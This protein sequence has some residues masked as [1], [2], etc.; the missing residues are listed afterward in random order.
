MICKGFDLMYEVVK[1]FYETTTPLKFILE[2][3]GNQADPFEKTLYSILDHLDNHIYPDENTHKNIDDAVKSGHPD[4]DFFLLFISYLLTLY[5]RDLMSAN[6]RDFILA[7][8]NSVYNIS[9]SLDISSF[10]TESQAYYYQSSGYYFYIKNNFSKGD[11]LNLLANQKMPK[12]SPRFFDFIIRA[13]QIFGNL[14]RLDFLP[15]FDKELLDENN[16]DNFYI[17]RAHFMNSIFTGN[18]ELAEKYL[19]ILDKKYSKPMQWQNRSGKSKCA[20]EV[21]KGNYEE[22]DIDYPEMYICLNYYKALKNKEVEVAKKQYSNIRESYLYYPCYYLYY[23]APYHQSFVTGWFEN[24]ETIINNKDEH[25][26]HYMMDF[27][28][29]RYFLYKNN[30]ELARFYYAQLIKNCVKHDAIGRLKFEMQFAVELS[31]NSFF[32]FTFPRQIYNSIDLRKSLEKAMSPHTSNLY[33][34]NRI[35]GNSKTINDVKK[36]VKLYADIHR[37]LLLIGETGE[38]KEIVAQAIHEESSIKNKPFLAINCG[39][40]TD[41][42]LQSELFGYE[43]GAFTGAVSSHKGIFEAAEDGIVFLDEFGEM[44]P[45]LQVSMLRILENNEILRVGGTKV[46]PIKCR[47]IAATNANL[48]ELI[49][50]K[51][52]REDLYHRLK[53]FTISIAPLRERKKDIPELINYFLNHQNKG[54]IQEFS[55]DLM[56]KFQDYRWPGNIRELKNEIDRIKILCGNKPLIEIDDVD[57]EWI[58][59]KS[60]VEKSSPIQNSESGSNYEQ[61]HQRVLEAKLSSTDKRLKQ[62]ILLFR[63]HKKLNRVQVA[64]AL[65]VSLLT[66]TRDLKKLISQGKI[67]KRTPTLSPKSHYFELKSL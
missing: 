60:F 58:A 35:I 8:G 5:S 4:K 59:K 14:G 24:I 9:C 62:I 57:I 52:F 20:L 67:E 37:P 17:F 6:R 10:R 48:E 44:S 16:E 36:K 46:K 22:P 55:K 65:E 18:I 50:Q 27:F 3:I 51:K 30:K 26:Y 53:Q 41:T 54:P 31:I 2:E 66:I 38:G 7:K 43:A 45:K 21:L 23:F 40:L 13:G 42:L 1:R 33:G 29:A 49:K 39:A 28:I 11:Q 32:D 15:R 25:H 64:E 12:N 56:A 63:E 34:L 61:M 47:I 19:T